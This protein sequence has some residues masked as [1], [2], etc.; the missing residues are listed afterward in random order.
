MRRP[1]GETA[2]GL[3]NKASLLII[4]NI[5]SALALFLVLNCGLQ[6]LNPPRDHQYSIASLGRLSIP[7]GKNPKIRANPAKK[8]NNKGNNIYYIP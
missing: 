8:A 4:K 1:V 2:R 7:T 5:K 3:L 6:A